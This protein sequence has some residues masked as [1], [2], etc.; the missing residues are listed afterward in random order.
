M[1]TD[2]A[3]YRYP[4]YHDKQDTP[5]KLNYE[6]LAEVLQGLIRVVEELTSHSSKV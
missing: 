1:I 4:H 5:E 2:T 3:N 6:K